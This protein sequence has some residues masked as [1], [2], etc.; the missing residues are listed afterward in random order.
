[1]RREK[2]HTVDEVVMR[3]SGPLI[4]LL[5]IRNLIT[6]LTPD[7]SCDIQLSAT[8]QRPR[9]PRYTLT[10]DLKKEDAGTDEGRSLLDTAWKM[11]GAETCDS[12]LTLKWP[13]AGTEP[14]N[15]AKILRS[16]SEGATEPLVAS[17]E[18]KVSRRP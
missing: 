9:A 13:E 16:L 3:T 18:A 7:R 6:R 14:E 12:T 8:I 5:H 4:N 11:K 15:A 2:F 1:M 10:F 17:L